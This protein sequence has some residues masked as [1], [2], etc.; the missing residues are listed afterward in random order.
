M[1]EKAEKYISDPSDGMLAEIVGEWVVNEKHPRLVNYIGASSGAR[2]RFHSPGK[3]SFIDLYCGPGR[4]TVRGSHE[5]NDGG[6]VAA[7]KKA[8]ESGAPFS[9]VH[10]GDI[11][12]EFVEICSNRLREL[13]ENVVTHVGPAE[14]TVKKVRQHLDPYGLHLAY[15]DP[16]NLETLNFSVINELS[17]LKRMDM[18]IHVS[19]QDLQRNLSRYVESE[20]SPLDSFAPGWRKAAT[21]ISLPNDGMRAEIIQHWLGLIRKLEMT[22]SD[23]FAL[24]KGSRGQRLYWLMFVSRHPLPDKLWNSVRKLDNQGELF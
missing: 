17:A 4:V 12:P 21:N 3:A 23:A 11:N 2:K 7:C 24:V 9:V 14:E 5:F 6:I 15:L 19:T 20:D 8:R 18:M 10:V 13:G 1:A 22:P 16:Y